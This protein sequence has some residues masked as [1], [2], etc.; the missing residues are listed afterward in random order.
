MEELIIKIKNDS[1]SA[2]LTIINNGLEKKKNISTEDLT[3]HLVSDYKLN[4]GLLPT[5]T[6]YFSGAKSNYNISIELPAKI[7]SMKVYS[8]GSRKKEVMEI[9]F[10]VCSFNF[11]IQ[12]YELRDTR[13]F[14]MKHPLQTEKDAM[15]CFPFGNVYGDG[16]VCWGSVKLSKVSKPMELVSIITLFLGSEFNGDLANNFNTKDKVGN[17]WELIAHLK[18]KTEF[19]LDFLRATNMN[20][21]NIFQE[22]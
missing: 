10:P 9:P 8:S 3:S 2:N 21:N 20:L 15:Y 18:D 6:R 12:N 19:S 11:N 14:S 7:R 1:P 4:T 13:I 5:G 16:R 22:R 17:F